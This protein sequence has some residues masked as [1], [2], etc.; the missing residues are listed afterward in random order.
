M[1]DCTKSVTVIILKDIQAKYVSDEETRRTTTYHNPVVEGENGYDDYMDMT[2][3]IKK[4]R[5][6]VVSFSQTLKS[7]LLHATKP[8][9]EAHSIIKTVMRQRP[10]SSTI[11]ASSRKHAAKLE[12]R[13]S[14][15]HQAVLQMTRGHQSVR[16]REWT[17]YNHRS[18][19][20]SY[21]GQQP[22]GQHCAGESIRQRHLT[23]FTNGFPTTSTVHTLVQ[24]RTI[25]V[26]L[27][28]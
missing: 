27:E 1:D 28:E 21:S 19:E 4:M 3:N 12:Q 25:E 8:G 9:S 23:T 10:P 11:F 7:V 14:T 15:L 22:Q 16:G 24:M 26:K 13:H 18:R 6:D 20:D 5:G 17:L 2:V